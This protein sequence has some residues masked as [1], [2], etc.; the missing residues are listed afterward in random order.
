[1]PNDTNETFTALMNL[2]NFIW[3]EARY[4]ETVR[5]YATLETEKSRT[6]LLEEVA[7]KLDDI[8]VLHFPKPETSTTYLRRAEARLKSKKQ[9]YMMFV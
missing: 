7:K 2:S 6:V 9:Y 4:F 3:E 1:M 8:L 5:G